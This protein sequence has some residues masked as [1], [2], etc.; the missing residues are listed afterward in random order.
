MAL[1]VWLAEFSLQS[2]ANLAAGALSP[3][4]AQRF[5]TA[6]REFLPA[7]LDGAEQAFGY[8]VDTGRKLCGP[9][10]DYNCPCV[11]VAF[12]GRSLQVAGGGRRGWGR[13]EE[14]EGGAGRVCMLWVVQGRS[15]SSHALPLLDVPPATPR[16][17]L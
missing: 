5:A 2:N 17:V 16:A 6:V 13:E 10:N 9:C 1:N 14:D 12:V 3:A 11:C 4:G 7:V 15:I 8:A